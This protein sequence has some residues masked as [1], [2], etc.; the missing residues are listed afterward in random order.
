MPR[1]GMKSH[2]FPAQHHGASKE[3]QLFLDCNEANIEQN[4]VDVLFLDEGRTRPKLVDFVFTTDSQSFGKKNI[5]LPRSLE[6]PV[7]EDAKLLALFSTQAHNEVNST[8]TPLLSSFTMKPRHSLPD[9]RCE[10]DMPSL[11]S[12]PS[13]SQSNP[14]STPPISS[15]H[16]NVITPDTKISTCPKTSCKPQAGSTRTVLLRK[17]FSWKNYPEL[18]AFLIEHRSEYLKYSARNYTMEQK[19]YN[20][21]LTQKLIKLASSNNYIFDDRDFSFS[22]IRDRIRCFYKSF[23][24]CIRKKNARERKIAII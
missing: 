16:Y 2:V 13:R 6:T 23:V 21:A 11:S 19:K 15:R 24:Q 18:E 7:L 3:T 5:L 4:N 14:C 17:K 8:Q 9:L 22:N 12:Q 20:N 10:E 1:P